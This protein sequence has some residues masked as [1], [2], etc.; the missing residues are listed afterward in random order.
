M[1]SVNANV[2]LTSQLA[3]HI[4]VPLTT[5]LNGNNT[6]FSESQPWISDLRCS[7]AALDSD[8]NCDRFKL[9]LPYSQHTL[10]WEVIFDRRR[11]NQAPDFIFGEEDKDFNPDSEK[12]EEKLL[13]ANSRLSFECSKLRTSKD[14]DSFEIL[15][16]K[17]NTN[18]YNSYF[19]ANF[20]IR[21]NLK[22]ESLPHLKADKI[23]R[24]GENF[25]RRKEL[26]E[27]FKQHFNGA[28][29][30][31]DSEN[32]TSINL[33]LVTS[34]FYFILHVSLPSGFPQSMPVLII[35]SVYHRMGILPYKETRTSYPYSPRWS[36]KE[37]V[38]RIQV[39]LAT[40][41]EDF[42]TSSLRYGKL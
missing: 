21:I 13:G 25:T 10:I 28:L 22:S 11:N 35:Q 1:A 30:E 41:I 9:H 14:F 29:L 32:Y 20:L 15:V 12:L 3:S 6:L 7:H 26:I 42:K 4:V 34:G 27:S 37:M 40:I 31:Y 23:N 19:E 8:T 5:F 2:N 33:L 24:I 17:K 39:Y 18:G 38:E 36:G 16:K